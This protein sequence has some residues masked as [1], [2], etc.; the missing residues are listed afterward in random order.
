MASASPVPVEFEVPSFKVRYGETVFLVGADAALGAWDAAAGLALTW[1]EGDTWRGSAHVVGGS[2]LEFKVVVST[3]GRAH[4][5][6][7][8]NREA[9]VPEG[10]AAA[11]VVCAGNGG[12]Q[13]AV[14]M[15]AKPAVEAPPAPAAAAAAEREAPAPPPPEVAPP[16]PAAAVEEQAPPA[17]DTAKA[18]E[19]ASEASVEAAPAPA[20]VEPAEEDAP[21]GAASFLPPHLA[22]AISSFSFAEDGTLTVVFKDGAENAAAL[23]ARL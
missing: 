13:V 10:A 1:N 11:T 16:V 4:W 2:T 7:G 22:A 3:G 15:A 18:H 8:A 5:E 17:P 20:A 19:P 6:G 14:K 9:A 21:A 12:V 23:A